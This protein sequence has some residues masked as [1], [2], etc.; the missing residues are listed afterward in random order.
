MKLLL[1]PTAVPSPPSSEGIWSYISGGLR[2]GI[3]VRMR[4]LNLRCSLLGQLRPLPAR[5]VVWALIH[6]YW[7][8]LHLSNAFAHIVWCRQDTPLMGSW[9]SEHS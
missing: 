3:L 7:I 5:T 4:R 6:R 9:R 1:A 2:R 8:W